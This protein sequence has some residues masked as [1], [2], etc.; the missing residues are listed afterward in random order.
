MDPH[1]PY[2]V[3]ITPG[4]PPP[5]RAHGYI[6]SLAFD[7]TAL[8][9]FRN[10]KP[11]ETI[12]LASVDTINVRQST[13]LVNGVIEIVHHTDQARAIVFTHGH[14]KEFASF[15]ETI[16]Q[17]RSRLPWHPAPLR[18]SPAQPLIAYGI[19]GNAITF[20]GYTV[21]VYVGDRVVQEVNLG[22]L[23]TIAVTPVLP[24]TGNLTIG[25]RGGG[26]SVV[27]FQA[28]NRPAFVRIVDAV[29]GTR[30]APPQP[31]V[32]Q[33]D[34]GSDPW[35]SAPIS[36]AGAVPFTAAPSSPVAP[37]PQPYIVGAGMSPRANRSLRR[38][39]TLSMW[40]EGVS[41]VLL[42]IPVL[43]V[44]AICGWTVLR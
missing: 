36:L 26:K 43:V 15:V 10:K 9:V 41:L 16:L 20:D 34:P 38:L 24:A 23:A 42:L 19:K 3:P 21:R 18:A 6:H 39:L 11:L 30:I 2:Q 40:T 37:V 13:R 29:E 7:G 44:L 22:Q 25:L 12:P 35:A 8:W 5:L 4:S 1:T 28:S 33:S 14:R 32:R 31:A 17:S 27:G